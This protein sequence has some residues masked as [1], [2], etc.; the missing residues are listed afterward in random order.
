VSTSEEVVGA[1]VLTTLE[2]VVVSSVLPPHDAIR[3]PV[4]ARATTPLNSF[5]RRSFGDFFILFP[6]IIGFLNKL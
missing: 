2:E 5:P 1:S 3:L 4:I 6:F